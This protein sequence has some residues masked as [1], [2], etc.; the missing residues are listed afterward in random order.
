MKSPFPYGTEK[1]RANHM[2]ILVVYG[3]P[4]VQGQL[5]VLDQAIGWARDA[6]LKDMNGL[7]GG[8]AISLAKDISIHFLSE[9]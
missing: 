1:V 7:D 2:C 6:G 5:G 9:F 3:D 4:Y 8:K